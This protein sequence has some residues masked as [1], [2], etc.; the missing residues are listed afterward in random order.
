MR[1]DVLDSS[2]PEKTTETLE[3]HRAIVAAIAKG[4]SWEARRTSEIHLQRTIEVLVDLGRVAPASNFFTAGTE[5]AS[6]R[7]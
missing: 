2:R 1:M 5:V 4:D 7:D 6:R 3:Q